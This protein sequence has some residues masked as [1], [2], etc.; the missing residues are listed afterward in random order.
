MIDFRDPAVRSAANQ[1]P[2]SRRS[3]RI[4]TLDVQVNIV[5]RVARVQLAQEFQNT[6]NRTIEASFVF[7]LPYDGA[8]EKLTLLVGKRR[9]RG[10][11]A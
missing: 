10:E 1:L 4:K 9:V 6:T 2:H 7:P 5:D 3:Y 8:I 11:T